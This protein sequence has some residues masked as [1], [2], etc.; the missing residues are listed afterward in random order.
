MIYDMLSDRDIKKAIK[1][2]KIGIDPYSDLLVQPAS[3]DLTLYDKVRVFDNWQTEVID[4]R[5]YVDPTRLVQIPDQ[6]FVVHPGDFLLGSTNEKISLPSNITGILEGKSS[7][8]RLGL[9]VHAA[10]G[11]VDP[12]FTG[13]LTLHLSNLSRLPIKIYSGMKIVQICFFTNTSPAE[14]PYGHKDL[15]S[16]YNYQKGPTPSKYHMEF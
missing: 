16:K 15:K 2:G 12:G 1:G 5:K 9:V 14:K 7:L 8:G 11:L 10:A 6:G 4:V 13:T 3:V